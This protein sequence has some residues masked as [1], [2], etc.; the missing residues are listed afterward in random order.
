MLIKIL[1]NKEGHE[2]V[3][4]IESESCKKMSK[5]CQNV[6]TLD[7]DILRMYILVFTYLLIFFL[8]YGVHILYNEQLL[9]IVRIKN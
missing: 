4:T 5:R 1:N 6:K 3:S 8:F 2:I 7:I 9:F